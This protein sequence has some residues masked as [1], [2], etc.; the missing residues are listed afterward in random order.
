[1]KERSAMPHVDEGRLTAYLDGMADVG[2]DKPTTAEIED[3]L[4]ACAECRGR[5]DQLRA[6]RERARGILRGTAALLGTTPSF[7][8]VINRAHRRTQEGSQ[9]RQLSRLTSLAWAAS[10]ILAVA[11]GWY[12]RQA[13]LQSTDNGSSAEARSSVDTPITTPPGAPAGASSERTVAPV[14]RAPVANRSRNANQPARAVAPQAGPAAVP[15]QPDRAMGRIAVAEPKA[16]DAPAPTLANQPES[17]WNEVT[18]DAALRQLGGRPLVIAGAPVTSYATSA[19][20]DK[21]LRITQQLADGTVLELI[22]RPAPA[23]LQAAEAKRAE[24]TTLSP[25]PAAP[26]AMAAREGD[27]RDAL[28]LPDDANQITVN[29]G[30]YLI[31][32]RPVITLHSSISRDSLRTL[33]KGLRQQ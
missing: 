15:R 5:L 30:S 33:A 19:A 28:N 9:R 6:E 26:R 14:R 21:A 32:L 29:S 3:H 18:L 4:A 1:M 20:G 2:S 12:V 27:A 22:E 10:L 16:A 7:Q 11:T 24:K 31:T 25:T 8:D 17:D 13:T 23:L